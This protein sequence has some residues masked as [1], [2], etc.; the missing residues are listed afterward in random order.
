MLMSHA[1]LLSSVE[2]CAMGL[3]GLQYFPCALSHPHSLVNGYFYCTLWQNGTVQ[4]PSI[5][6]LRKL[7]IK[8][9]I[10]LGT[11]LVFV[12]QHAC[13]PSSLH[14]PVWQFHSADRTKCM[15]NNCKL[16]Y[17]FWS[18]DFSVKTTAPFLPSLSLVQNLI[19]AHQYFQTSPSCI[20]QDQVPVLPRRNSFMAQPP[21]LLL[22]MLPHQEVLAKIMSCAWC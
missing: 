4:G 1:C 9:Q 11:Y 21:P 17:A 8:Q 16:H 5:F 15:P 10:T 6:N 3:Q 7:F 12:T 20:P 2:L 22:M 18:S 19:L 14:S 13:L